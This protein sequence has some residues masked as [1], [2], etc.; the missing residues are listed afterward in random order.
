[1]DCHPVPGFKSS[2]AENL[3]EAERPALE[4]AVGQQFVPNSN[5]RSMAERRH[6]RFESRDQVIWLGW[7]AAHRV[8]VTI[9]CVATPG[10]AGATSKVRP[11][12]EP[13]SDDATEGFYQD[14]W[15]ESVWSG[16]EPNRDEQMRIE[17]L[18]RV[19]ADHRLG[20]SILDVG[21]G[22][23]VLTRHFAKHGEIM[24]IDIV[25]AAV[26]RG[27]D[28]FPEIDLQHRTLADVNTSAAGSFDLVVSSEVLEHVPRG[29]QSGFL[30]EIHR[31]LRPGGFV[32][33][34]T[35][36]GELHRQGRAH[37]DSEQPIEDWLSEGEL[38]AML[39]AAGLSIVHRERTG[40]YPISWWRTPLVI[41][42]VR[43]LVARSSV[44]R[45][46]VQRAGIYQVVLAQKSSSAVD[47]SSDT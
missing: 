29:E 33:L 34:T 28:L 1:M 20:G 25:E 10:P 27:R 37:V 4:V 38:D 6:R 5:R 18:E 23:G 46:V 2:L 7:V 35:P 26:R 24:G 22:R 30:R 36:R 47:Q 44:L 12:S 41:S 3:G 40:V 17:A 42:P 45:R 32:L 8:S 21:C 15:T 39:T 19:I 43:R 16:S 14:F 13:P 9:G 11:M 31:A